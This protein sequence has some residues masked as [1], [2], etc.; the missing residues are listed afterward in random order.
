[1]TLHMRVHVVR[2][3]AVL[4][5]TLVQREFD[6]GSFVWVWLSDDNAPEPRFLT[7]RQAVAYMDE[8]LQRRMA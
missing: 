6:T 4:G 5:F 2:D 7:R 8:K 1:M 3:A